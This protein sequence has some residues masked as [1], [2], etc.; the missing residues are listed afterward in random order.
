MKTILSILILAFVFNSCKKEQTNGYVSDGSVYIRVQDKIGMD[1]L[2]QSN[3]GA[4]LKSDIKIFYLSK[5][6]KEEVY[7]SNYD[8]PRNFYISEEADSK[9]DFWMTLFLNSSAD[10]A[11]PITYIKW[12]E[13][14][15]D[16]LKCDV[17]RNEGLVSVQNIWLNDSLVWKAEDYSKGPRNIYIIK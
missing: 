15:T 4:Y 16:T 14:D 13:N 6:V 17:Y 9:G 8:Y 3:P 5:G 12:S 7:H 1:L 2:N 10:E 11:Y